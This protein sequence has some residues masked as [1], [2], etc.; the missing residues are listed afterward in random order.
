MWY[1]STSFLAINSKVDQIKA[2]VGEGVSLRTEGGA[3]YLT[4]GEPFAQ[5]MPMEG[6]ETLKAIYLLFNIQAPTT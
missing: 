4:R 5:Y 2:A 3:V 6:D 1:R